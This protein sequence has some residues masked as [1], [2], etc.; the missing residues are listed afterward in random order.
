MDIASLLDPDESSSSPAQQPPHNTS[1]DIA[2]MAASTAVATLQ[3]PPPLHQFDPPASLFALSTATTAGVAAA[4][5]GPLS[6]RSSIQGTGT[7]SISSRR[8]TLTAS[9]RL[10][11]GGVGKR[12]IPS[13]TL[14]PPTKKQGKWLPAEDALVIK[15]RGSGMK[16]DEISKRLLGRSSISCRLHYQN[17]LEHREWDEEQKDKLA[18]LYER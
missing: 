14:E 5:A 15:L 8:P 12:S 9:S 16:W 3:L 6:P 4:A 18:R 17:Y 11:S 10:G 2:P 7:Y 1:P 13:H